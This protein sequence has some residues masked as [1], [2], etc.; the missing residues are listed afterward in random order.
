MVRRPLRPSFS[1]EDE[2][3]LI[4]ALGNARHMALK[5]SSAE[6]YGSPRH[7]RCHAVTKSI[8]TLAE[9]L[10]GDATFFHDKPHGSPPRSPQA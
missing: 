9:D 7:Q 2:K 6:M 1:G 8:D 10:T 3:R 4:D 5:C